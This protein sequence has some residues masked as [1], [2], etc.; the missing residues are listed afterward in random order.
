MSFLYR[1]HKRHVYVKT[2]REKGK[3]NLVYMPSNAIAERDEKEKKRKTIFSN[4][5][6]TIRIAEIADIV[7]RKHEGTVGIFGILGGAIDFRALRLI[8][9]PV[10][11]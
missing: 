11:G 9:K 4:T 8:L 10:V 2:Q 7:G 1:Y 5:N 6:H 3:G